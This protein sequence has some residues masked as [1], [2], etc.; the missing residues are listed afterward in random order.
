ML[1]H[2]QE[3]ELLDPWEV[4]VGL[5]DFDRPKESFLFDEPNAT[6]IDQDFWRQSYLGSVSDKYSTFPSPQSIIE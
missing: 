6:A 2:F 4:F 5:A 1:G 3:F